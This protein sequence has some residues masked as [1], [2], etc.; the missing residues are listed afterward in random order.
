MNINQLG[1]DCIC[2]LN[3]PNMIGWIKK[4]FKKKV[5]SKES[6]QM[7]ILSELDILEIR[8]FQKY[9]KRFKKTS[10]PFV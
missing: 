5:I 10:S 8:E 9:P 4:L 1:F 3:S 7:P 6:I 2:K